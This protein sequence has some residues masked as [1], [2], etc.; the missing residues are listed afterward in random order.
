MKQKIL[1]AI[2]AFVGCLAVCSQANAQA[3]DGYTSIDY[4]DSTGLIDAYSETIL[5][6]DVACYYDA[7][8]SMQVY[9]DSGS[10]ITSVSARDYDMIGF[11]SVESFFFADAATTYTAKGTHSAYANYYDYEYFWDPDF[12][13]YIYGYY[14]YDVWF[15][16]FYEPYWI[17]NPWYYRFMN[18]YGFTQQRRRLPR[19]RMG[20]THDTASVT[21]PNLKPHHVVVVADQTT[22]N[23]CG[24]L[25]RQ[26]QF[27]VVTRGRP[28]TVTDQSVDETF[29]AT[30]STCNN[31]TVSPSGCRATES[32]GTFQDATSV[33]CPITNSTCGF[34]HKDV[35]RWCSTG[36]API[37]IATLNKV[38]RPF[39]ITINGNNTQFSNGTPIF[40]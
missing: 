16:G 13:Q 7:Y 39:E 6:F 19:V 24:S 2:L 3:V 31:S 36:G 38:A 40:K 11:I 21:T 22:S 20:T 32:D 4:D 27:R 26:I 15:F 35:W 30:T 10:L 12:G 33:G 14:Y 17:Y 8:V 5:D 18:P 28:R 1:I 29:P 37:P 23:S 9:N 25:R 34:S